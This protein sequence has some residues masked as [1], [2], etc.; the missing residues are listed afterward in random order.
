[1]ARAAHG[2]RTCAFRQRGAA[3]SLR[4]S[5]AARRAD[6]LSLEHAQRLEHQPVPLPQPR[7]RLRPRAGGH[8][9]SVPRDEA[10]QALPGKSRLPVRRGDT[11]P[12]IQAVPGLM[13]SRHPLF[14]EKLARYIVEH[15][16]REAEVLRE[17]REATASNPHAGMQIGAD[18]GQF[19]ALLVQAIGARRCLEIGTFTGYSALAV[20]LALPAD[21]RVL[22]CDINAEWTAL[23]R[24]FWRKAG[25][26]HKIELRLAPALETLAQL[27]GPFDFV[28]I[29]ADKENYQNYYERSLALLRRGGLI[30]V[31][32]TLWSGAVAA[33]VA[34]P[35]ALRVPSVH[36]QQDRVG[37]H[38]RRRD[39]KRNVER[40][41]GESDARMP[42][43]EHQRRARRDDG[44]QRC[45]RAAAAQR[46]GEVARVILVLYRPAESHAAAGEPRE[47]TLDKTVDALAPGIE[48]RRR[49]RQAR[50]N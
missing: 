21:G 18:Q 44:G 12:R 5:R 26:E 1:M 50:G 4:I 46:S 37:K 31:D 41:V 49:E 3:L 34:E 16:V 15:S 11:Q 14:P 33:A 10:I 45:Q 17:L 30:A 40:P 28:F 20:A 48:L 43:A 24:R 25:V 38:F 27:E 6:A 36:R 22:C 8:A 13:A 7:R 9:S 32:N 19:M 2:R 42:F 47:R 39:G 29:D 23:A 35:V